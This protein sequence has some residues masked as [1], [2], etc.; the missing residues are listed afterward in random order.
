MPTTMAMMFLTAPPSSQPVTSVLVYGR[1]Y[2]VWHAS[3]SASAVA[4]ET[5]ATTVA[6]ICRLAISRA[7]FGPD[8]TATRAAS[9]ASTEVMT[10]L[11]RMLVPSSMPLIRLT[12][13]AP[14]GTSGAQSDRL[15]RSVCAGTANTTMSAPA[16]ASAGS[17]TAS[18][19]AV[20]SIPG[21]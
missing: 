13:S 7:R 5:L 18:S 20:S 1:K 17:Q 19:A 9:A 2:G 16:S 8:T 11:I 21:R 3:C 15:A 14:G 6:A 10:S 12:S 4:G